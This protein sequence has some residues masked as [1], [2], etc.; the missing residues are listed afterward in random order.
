M[1]AA[2]STRLQPSSFVS[3]LVRLASPMEAV[4]PTISPFVQPRYRSPPLT[5]LLLPRQ[6]SSFDATRVLLHFDLA[7]AVFPWTDAR[8][9]AIGAA[10]ASAGGSLFFDD[11]LSI[12][13]VGASL[14]ARSPSPRLTSLTSSAHPTVLWHSSQTQRSTLLRTSSHSA[15]SSIQSTTPSST[16]S[17][18]TASSTTSSATTP[19]RLLLRRSRPKGSSLRNSSASRMATGRSITVSTRCDP[20]CIPNAT[21]SCVPSKS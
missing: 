14:R 8:R 17:K 2:L 3:H 10:R 15:S 5:G 18:S 1:K 6:P 12:A 21:T 19:T 20:C 7:P 16:T 9:A 4:S 13:A 11:L